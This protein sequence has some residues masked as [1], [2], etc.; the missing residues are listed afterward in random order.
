MININ[1]I[2]V[3]ISQKGEGQG[4]GRKGQEGASLASHL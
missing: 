1:F 4:S 2:K 3:A